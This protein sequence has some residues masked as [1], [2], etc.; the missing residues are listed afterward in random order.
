MV[1]VSRNVDDAVFGFNGN[2]EIVNDEL[3]EA[4]MEGYTDS[5]IIEYIERKGDLLDSYSLAVLKLKTHWGFS[6]LVVEG[7]EPTDYLKL[8]MTFD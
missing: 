6:E 4:I 5:N 8:N 3:Y 2:D 7:N 1:E